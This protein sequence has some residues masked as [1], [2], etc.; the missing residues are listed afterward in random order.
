MVS[1]S[2][3]SWKGSR[4]GISTTARPS[5]VAAYLD[6]EEQ[7]GLHRLEPWLGYARRVA[8]SRDALRE[9]LD[10]LQA[11]GRSLA[12]YGAPAKGMTLLACCGIGPEG[13]PTWWTKARI[14]RAC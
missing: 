2:S 6:R 4:Y 14:S 9:E 13:C 12:G 5:S 3:L 8:Q 7:V 1:Y 10:R 11:T